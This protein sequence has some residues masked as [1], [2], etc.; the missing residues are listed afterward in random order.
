MGCL[1]ARPQ[2]WMAATAPRGDMQG[3]GGSE[4]HPGTP[5]PAELAQML[6][7]HFPKA[8]AG[9][10]RANPLCRLLATSME[11]RRGPRSSCNPALLQHLVRPF[12]AE[13]KEASKPRATRTCTHRCNQQESKIGCYSKSNAPRN[14]SCHQQSLSLLLSPNVVPV[15]GNALSPPYLPLLSSPTS[16]HI[17]LLNDAHIPSAA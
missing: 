17:P 11:P 15:R 9:G 7:P 3:V 6:V 4:G 13:R 2:G 14:N 16:T 5:R 1:A 8:A 10:L 12:C